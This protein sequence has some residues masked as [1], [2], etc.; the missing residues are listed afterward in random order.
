M[1][2]KNRST[3]TFA[4]KKRKILLFT[5]DKL[6]QS[7]GNL[8]VRAFAKEQIPSQLVVAQKIAA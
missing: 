2:K 1:L 3:K 4:L 6:R 8:L 5:A 7:M